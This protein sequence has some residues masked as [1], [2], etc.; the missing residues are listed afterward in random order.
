MKLLNEIVKMCLVF[1][2]Y[3][4][5]C[6]WQNVFAEMCLIECLDEMCLI[7]CICLFDISF[8][9]FDEI[10]CLFDK[11]RLLILIFFVYLTKCICLFD[12]IYLFI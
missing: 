11:I 7:K 10:F 9:L 12:K 4:I 3:L 2:L 1:K 6:V 8:C 5:K